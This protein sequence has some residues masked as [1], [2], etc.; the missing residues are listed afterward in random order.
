MNVAPGDVFDDEVKMRAFSGENFD[1]SYN[2]LPLAN[3]LDKEC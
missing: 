3:R 2:G 1:Y